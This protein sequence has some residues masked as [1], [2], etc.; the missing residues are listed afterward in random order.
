MEVHYLVKMANE[1][2]SFFKAE[3]AGDL[4]DAAR[5]V[6]RHIKRYWDPRMRRQIV[7][8]YREGKGEGLDVLAHRAIG[9][10]AQEP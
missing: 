1:I 7:D 5:Q 10:L 6:A 4:E 8:H 9:L 2:G 3:A